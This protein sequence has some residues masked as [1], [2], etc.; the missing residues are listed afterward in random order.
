M[1]DYLELSLACLILSLPVF[2]LAVAW[3]GRTRYYNTYVVRRAQRTAY[4][5]ALVTASLSTAAYIGYWSWRICGLYR[6]T[7][8]LTLVIIVDRLLL[9]GCPLSV[10]S[11]V[12]LLIG[13]GPYRLP[14]TLSTL[15]V[16]LQVWLHRG[17]VHWA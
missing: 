6:V 12:C 9:V 3:N 8:P 11:I 4:T 14:L 15:W 16:T 13:R 10:V 7:L 17:T 5:V 1:L 2:V